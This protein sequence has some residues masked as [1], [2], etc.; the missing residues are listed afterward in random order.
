[1]EM[2]CGIL[3]WHLML[4]SLSNISTFVSF[5]AA[6]QMLFFSAWHLPGHLRHIF[7]KD[8]IHKIVIYT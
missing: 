6:M 2:V 4:F 1:M 3:V 7:W 8:I 5:A